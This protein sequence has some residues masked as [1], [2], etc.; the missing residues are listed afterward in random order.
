MRTR[1]MPPGLAGSVI[2]I[3]T[4]FPAEQ[5]AR[6]GT[7]VSAVPGLGSSRARMIT[8]ASAIPNR[9]IQ[10]SSIRLV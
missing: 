2:S 4:S 5:I 10:G 9:T 1:R 7:I 3:A 6:A 8:A